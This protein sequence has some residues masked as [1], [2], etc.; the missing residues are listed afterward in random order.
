M[1]RVRCP[2][3]THTGRRGR[4]PLHQALPGWSSNPLPQLHS[5]PHLIWGFGLQP[6]REQKFRVRMTKLVCMKSKRPQV[7]S[8]ARARFGRL[9]SMLSPHRQTGTSATPRHPRL[10]FKSPKPASLL[11]QSNLGIWTSNSTQAMFRVRCPSSTHTGRRG[12][13]P[14]HALPGWTSTST[15]AMFRVRMTMLNAHRQT[16]TSATPRPPRLDFN[17]H[18]SYVSR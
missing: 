5:F 7:Y 4:L 3:S 11:P 10:E 14:L 13:L 12:R 15:R 9:N 18:A 17:Q 8:K 6:A 1:F 16:G 2:S